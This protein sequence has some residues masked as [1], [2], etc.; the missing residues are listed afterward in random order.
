VLGLDVGVIAT[1][2][3]VQVTDDAGG[4]RTACWSNAGHPPPVLV[5]PD[6]TARLLETRPD[7]LIGLDPALGRSDHV[8][9]LEPGSSL[10]LYTDGLV[11]RRGVA[12]QDSLDWLVAVLTG[13]QR[14]TAEE[15]SDHLLEHAGGAVEDDVALLVLRVLD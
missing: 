7:L 1:A 10:V 15:L 12:L 14:R 8:V 3:L 13:Q 11:E 2:V 5:A 9:D 6:G 4:R